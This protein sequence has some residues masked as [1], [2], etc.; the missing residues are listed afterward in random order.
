MTAE[1]DLQDSLWQAHTHCLSQAGFQDF[2]EKLALNCAP[3][4]L[5]DLVEHCSPATV[6]TAVTQLLKTKQ[7]VV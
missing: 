4:T 5:V 1:F 7:L 3:G 6:E 2:L